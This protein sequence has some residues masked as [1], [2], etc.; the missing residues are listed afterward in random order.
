MKTPYFEAVR[1]A[2]DE[3]TKEEFEMPTVL[4]FSSIERIEKPAPNDDVFQHRGAKC[5]VIQT[6]NVSLWLLMDYDLM[7]SMWLEWLDAASSIQSVFR[8]N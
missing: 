3:N 7:R 1:I 8:N 6:G 5:I 2:M 4:L